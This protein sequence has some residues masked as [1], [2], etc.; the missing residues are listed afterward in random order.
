M[1]ALRSLFVAPAGEA[2]APLKKAVN[3]LLVCV[4]VILVVGCSLGAVG[5]TL[6]FD[7]VGQY[8]L[9]IFDGF[10]LTVWL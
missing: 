1:S 7:F 6:N 3:Y 8:R 10:M 2:V 9:R 4:A 5:I